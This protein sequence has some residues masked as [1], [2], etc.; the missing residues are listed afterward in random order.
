MSDTY[1]SPDA[2][3]T[4][5]NVLAERKRQQDEIDRLRA[6]IT[7]LHAERDELLEALNDMVD[8]VAD[9]DLSAV[10]RAR[11]LLDAICQRQRT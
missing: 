1:L 8:L 5:K 9:G 7:R 4:I 10:R 6:V 3:E 2:V 11:R